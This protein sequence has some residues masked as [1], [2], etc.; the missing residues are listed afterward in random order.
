MM[1]KSYVLILVNSAYDPNKI[2]P[3]QIGHSPKNTKRTSLN[4]TKLERD[5]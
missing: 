2:S 3:F 4:K 5:Y 1:L